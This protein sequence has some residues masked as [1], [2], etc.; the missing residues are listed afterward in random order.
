M[1]LGVHSESATLQG[2]GPGSLHQVDPPSVET[3][4]PGLPLLS[5]EK[6]L[7]SASQ[8]QGVSAHPTDPTKLVAGFQDNGTQVYSGMVN[9][10]FGADS[11]NGDGGVALYDQI[12][13]THIY[14]DFSD[15]NNGNPG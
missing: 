2:A 5:S 7:I 4:I 1:R 8:V 10:W 14:H 6:S 9:T 11:E 3:E 13:P 12:D 15:D